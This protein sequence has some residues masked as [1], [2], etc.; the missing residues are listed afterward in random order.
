MQPLRRI[1]LYAAMAV[2]IFLGARF[3]VDKIL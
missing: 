3:I 1:V 2:D